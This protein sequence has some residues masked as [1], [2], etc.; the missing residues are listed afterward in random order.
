MVYEIFLKKVSFIFCCTLMLFADID[1]QKGIYDAAEEM[2]RFDNKMNRLIAEHNQL[3]KEDEKIFEESQIEDFEEIESGYRLKKNI[4]DGNGTKVE[5]LLENRLLTI[6]VSRTKKE[7][8][9]IGKERSYESTMNRSSSS[10]YLPADADK[11]SM[12]QEY[13]DGVLKITFS[14]N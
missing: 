7:V 12:K 5:V 13:I 4:S 9:Q 3:D 11:N 2:I 10:L 6:S 1:M 8:I 14:K